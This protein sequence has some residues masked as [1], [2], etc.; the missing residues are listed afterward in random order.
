MVGPA[1]SMALKIW[2]RMPWT[3]EATAITVVTPMTTPRMVSADRSLLARMES[4]AIAAPSP[5]FLRSIAHSIL[6]AVMGSSLEA[7]VAG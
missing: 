6:S 3:S 5:T 7:R 2:R 4:R 1:T